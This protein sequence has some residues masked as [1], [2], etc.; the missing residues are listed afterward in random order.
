MT[1]TGTNRY[2]GKV[3]VLEQIREEGPLIAAVPSPSHFGNFDQRPDGSYVVFAETPNQ[4]FGHRLES[5]GAFG[6]AALGG[7]NSRGIGLPLVGHVRF[8][9]VSQ[10]LPE[11]WMFEMLDETVQRARETLSGNRPMEK[12]WDAA[13]YEQALANAQ[14]LRSVMAK[15]LGQDVAEPAVGV[16]TRLAEP[17]EV[18]ECAD[19]DSPGRRSLDQVLAPLTETGAQVDVHLHFPGLAGH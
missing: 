4:V 2:T 9:V 3:C 15:A 18:F 16:L 8:R 11:P 17:V 1:M 6:I 13:W 14:R 10:D 12:G 7:P 19:G 5:D